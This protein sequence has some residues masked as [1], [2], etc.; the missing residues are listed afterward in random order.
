M[1][2]CRI[3]VC[4]MTIFMAV[5]FIRADTQKK[6]LDTNAKKVS[7]IIGQ[8]NGSSMLQRCAE[9]DLNAFFS[10]FQEG[11]AGEISV[12]S[13]E[14]SKMIMNKFQQELQL[15][16]KTEEKRVELAERNLKEDKKFLEVKK[17]NVQKEDLDTDTK[18]VG[19]IIGQSNG[20][21]MLQ[22][23]VE[24]DLDAFF[25]G[26]KEG[27]SGKTSVFSEEERKMIMN[28]FQQELQFYAKAD[29]KSVELAKKNL[30]E[31]RKFLEENKKKV[32]VKTIKS[33][34]QYKVLREGE[35]KHPT[36]DDTVTVHYRGTT[37][38][39]KEF[40]SSY[41]REQPS[42][43]PLKAVIKG[44][45]EGVQ[46]MKPGAKFEFYIPADLAYGISGNRGI[47]PN[48]T[49]IFEVELISV[50]KLKNTKQISTQKELETTLE[51]DI[52]YEELEEDV[53]G[54]YRKW[55]ERGNAD[56]QNRLAFSYY[57]G[58]DV[59]KDLKEALK[60]WT[61]AAEQG[62]A[63]AQNNLGEMYLYGEGTEK[64]LDQARKWFR[65]AA[66]QGH[67]EAKKNLERLKD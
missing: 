48:S 33:G 22:Q 61:K 20:S 17:K 16:A 37:L 60:W 2:N 10:G 66:D 11:Y 13:E 57:E 67:A 59:E 46:L 50:T 7:Y 1:K 51:E 19:Y 34:L 45:T 14:E 29:A 15:H 25:N 41:K 38:D 56:A 30:K 53:A 9:I 55:A 58:E 40:D 52:T 21:S 6:D 27:Y 24:I 31:G 44:W 39:G 3:I 65:K 63:K 32:G 12:F 8:S 4:M 54:Y 43:F 28:R 26:F 64:D 62:L 18:Q 42:T 47:E 36:A 5:L 49:L 23:Y 35:G